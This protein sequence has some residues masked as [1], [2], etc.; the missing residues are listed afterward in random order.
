M[1]YTSAFLGLLVGYTLGKYRDKIEPFS[2]D[3]SYQEY[4]V[5]YIQFG[6][7][8]GLKTK[9]KLIPAAKDTYGAI[10]L[11]QVSNLFLSNLLKPIATPEFEALI[12]VDIRNSGRSQV[13]SPD[14][15]GFA[16]WHLNYKPD[17]PM[18]FGLLQGYKV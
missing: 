14:V 2:F 6:A 16:I 9:M 8:V 11:N 15:E 13:K 7:S 1:K 3:T 18:D 4:P 12:D 17:F 5:A 10:F